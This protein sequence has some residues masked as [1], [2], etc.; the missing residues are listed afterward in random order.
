MANQLLR[1]ATDGMERIARTLVR[2]E[3]SDATRH[4]ITPLEGVYELLK[5]KEVDELQHAFR[6][7][8]LEHV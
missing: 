2:S 4:E 5:V 3:S 1:A 6:R 8:S 7:D